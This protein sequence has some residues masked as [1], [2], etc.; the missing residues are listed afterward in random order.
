MNCRPLFILV[1][2][3]L[4]MIENKLNHRPKKRLGFKTSHEV[5]YTSLSRFSLRT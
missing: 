2:A 3:T 4:T 5:F 1:T